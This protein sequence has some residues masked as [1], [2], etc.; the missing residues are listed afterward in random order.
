MVMTNVEGEKVE[1]I[2]VITTLKEEP[3]TNV[4][5]KGK[6]VPKLKEEIPKQKK[7]MG[8]KSVYPSHFYEM[9]EGEQAID[10]TPASKAVQ[11]KTIAGWTIEDADMIKEIN[12]GTTE[13]PKW[14]V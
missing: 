11:G 12:L 10:Q 8:E 2:N 6:Q 1:N 14:F 7:D 3:K 13:D 4:K 9:K 5:K